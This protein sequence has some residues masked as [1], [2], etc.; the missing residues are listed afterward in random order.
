[1]AH[2]SATDSGGSAVKP[3]ALA[4]FAVDQVQAYA[5]VG[6]RGEIDLSTTPAFRDALLEATRCSARVIVDLTEVTFL[7]SFGIGVIAATT[8]TSNHDQ[9][10]ASL[11]L[12]GPSGIVRKALEISGVTRLFPIFATVEEAVEHLAS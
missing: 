10:N 3:G 9:Q 6:A 7:D 12:V 4:T 5:V 1:M 2:R 11:C 8:L